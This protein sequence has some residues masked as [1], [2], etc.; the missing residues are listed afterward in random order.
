MKTK[1]SAI[2]FIII[3]NIITSILLM[4]SVIKNN[5]FCI[6]DFWLN[7]IILM[8]LIWN[9]LLFSLIKNIEK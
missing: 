5:L 1:N 2:K 4:L 7:L 6:T 3:Y 9:V 8:L